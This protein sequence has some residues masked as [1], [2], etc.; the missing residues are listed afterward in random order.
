MQQKITSQEKP[1]TKIRSP[2]NRTLTIL[3]DEAISLLGETITLNNSVSADSIDGKVIYQDLFDCIEHLPDSFID[4]LVIDPPYNLSKTFAGTKFSKT[5]ASKYEQ[6]LDSWMQKL[7][8]CLK[9]S[10]SIY[11][12]CDWQSSSS[13]QNVLQRY[14]IVR[15]RITWEREKGR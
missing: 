4:L 15:N 11:V 14:F 2:R 3:P 6:W 12:C 7:I 5:S 10:A 9:P 1:K 13:I 8:R